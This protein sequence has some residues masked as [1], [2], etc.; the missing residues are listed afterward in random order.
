MKKNTLTIKYYDDRF[1]G[2]AANDEIYCDDTTEL[3]YQLK[4]S[5]NKVIY[6]AN[7]IKLQTSVELAF[8]HKAIVYL[9]ADLKYDFSNQYDKSKSNLN[10]SLKLLKLAHE[11]QMLAV[12]IAIVAKYLKH[13]IPFKMTL[14]SALSLLEQSI[15]P[16]LD[17]K[18]ALLQFTTCYEQHIKQTKKFIAPAENDKIIKIK[19]SYQHELL[20]FLI[21]TDGIFVLT[22]GMGSGK[23]IGI[24]ALF[25]YL[26]SIIGIRPTLLT[27]GIALSKQ[28]LSEDD[29]RHYLKIK[30]NKKNKSIAHLDGLVCCIN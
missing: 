12:G 22:S 8:K 10:N 18:A 7:E 2:E 9:N 5:D 24:K 21:N 15:N 6:I 19:L 26:C 27:P 3:K 30:K 4:K 20:D 25:E 23:S 17:S 16:L 29:K 1:Y 14:E 13:Q 11:P 28:I